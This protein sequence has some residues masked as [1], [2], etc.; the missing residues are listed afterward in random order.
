MAF[1]D[2]ILRFQPLWNHWTVDG[3]LGEGSYGRVYRVVRSDLGG[4]YYSAVKHIVV[5]RSEAEI[6]SVHNMGMDS[7]QQPSPRPTGRPTRFTPTPT[8]KTKPP[9]CPS[10]THGTS[11]RVESAVRPCFEPMQTTRKE[12]PQ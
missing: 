6:K 4:T 5:P 9:A 10:C 2:S 11:T 3:F 8:A 12:P 1:D 7:A